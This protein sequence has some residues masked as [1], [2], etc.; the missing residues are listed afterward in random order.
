MLDR[1]FLLGLV[2]QKTA[3][4]SIMIQGKTFFVDSSEITYSDVPVNRPTI[5]GGIYHTD[6][7]AFKAR[8]TI[9]D[10]MISS[11]LSKTMLGPN[12]EFAQIEI[13]ASNK[14]RIFANL[15]NYVQKSTGYDL[16]L[17]LVDTLPK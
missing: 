15:T 11:V 4:Q 10:N 6:T 2:A 16:N 13:I 8:V 17:V 5:R 12:Q 7:M 3:I 1:E 14:T 9:S